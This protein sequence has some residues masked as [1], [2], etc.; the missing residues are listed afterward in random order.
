MYDMVVRKINNDNEIPY[1]LLSL[2]GIIKRKL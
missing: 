1:D 2:D